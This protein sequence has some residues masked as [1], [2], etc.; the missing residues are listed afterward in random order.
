MSTKLRSRTLKATSKWDRDTPPDTQKQDKEI[1]S[2]ITNGWTAFAKHCDIFKGNIGTWLKRQ[3][4]TSPTVSASE[5]KFPFSVL[6][7]PLFYSQVL[8]YTAE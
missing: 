8:I 1:Q 4:H 2:R 3:M 5:F 6:F 7:C